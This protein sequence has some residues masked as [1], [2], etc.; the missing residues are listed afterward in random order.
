MKLIKLIRYMP[1][2]Q[3]IAVY[4]HETEEYKYVGTVGNLPLLYSTYKVKSVEC[5]DGDNIT[6]EV[7]KT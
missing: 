2:D 3:R 7:R 6:I 1:P 5:T 4:N